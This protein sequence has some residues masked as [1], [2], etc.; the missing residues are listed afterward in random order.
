MV[1]IDISL[2]E[3]ADD[4]LKISSHSGEAFIGNES[5]SGNRASYLQSIGYCPQF[6]SIIEVAAIIITIIIVS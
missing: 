1:M 6:D 5:L 4:H 3:N 2:H